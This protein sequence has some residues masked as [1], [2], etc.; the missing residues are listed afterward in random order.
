MCG[1]YYD[2]KY[3]SF[4]DIESFY[5]HCKRLK[6][7]LIVATNLGFDLTSAFFDTHH[8]TEFDIV[9]NGGFMLMGYNRLL[10]IKFIDTLN[11]HKA[12]VKE[13][14]DILNLPKFKAPLFLGQK[15]QTP[16]EEKELRDYNKRDCEVSYFFSL[17]FQ[18]Q[19]NLLGGELKITIA[20]T[21]LD[22]WKRKYNHKVLVKEDEV[23]RKRGLTINLK[24]KIFNAYY[25]GRTETLQR[26][27]FENL[28]YYD[29]NSLYPSVMVNALPLPNS[30]QY[31]K[32]GDY[33]Q[34]FKRE[35]VSDVTIQQITDE[36]PLLPFRQNGKL[37]FPSG[38]FRGWYSHVELREA[39]N[40]G[41]VITKTHETI[42]YSLTFK[43]FSL[44]V[45]DLYAKRTQAKKN[46]ST[47]QLIYKIL[48]NSLYGKFGE[49]KHNVVEH[50]DILN[51][52]KDILSKMKDKYFDKIMNINDDGKGYF[53]R[54]EE[55]TSSHVFPILPVYITALARIK[56]WRVAR[57]VDVVYMDTDSIVTPDLLPHSKEL[58]ALDLEHHLD[59]A[60]FVKP[61]M[62]YFEENKIK[63]VK[64]KGVPRA[65][66]EQFED[67]LNYKPVE[68]IKFTKLKESIRRNFKVN[69]IL[70]MIKHLDLEDTKRVWSKPF[71]LEKQKSEAIQIE[72]ISI[73]NESP[74]VIR[75]G[76]GHK[77]QS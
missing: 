35:G 15:P 44:Y 12:S 7:Y 33:K 10:D 26:G 67:V 1:L 45:N 5:N 42:S 66:Y 58:G 59:K 65:S 37:L 43:P 8:W 64:M 56:L 70:N 62:Y 24:D 38:Q 61:K 13:L 53:T 29:F 20:S 75:G 32:E 52:S 14:G 46:G 41:Y 19:I 71:S 9:S 4:Y 73:Q 28:N 54:E 60:I 63:T 22:L 49:R 16:I 72:Q 36:L 17:W 31:H 2:N 77:M 57:T 30:V 11:W 48:M 55:C 51:M 76:Y 27:F 21:S 39:V 3:Y 50:F 74:L 18:E 47:E 6:G 23:L 68:Y 34:I 25:G 69:S 40:N